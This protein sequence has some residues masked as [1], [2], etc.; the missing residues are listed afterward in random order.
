MKNLLYIMIVLSTISYGQVGRKN[1]HLNDNNTKAST[2]DKE[3]K[4]LYDEFI[5]EGFSQFYIEG[6]GGPTSDGIEILG[7][8]NGNWEIYYIERGQRQKTL[9]SS[10][11]KKE[12]IDFYRN[13]IYRIKHHHL[14]AFTRSKGKIE[15]IKILLGENSI[16]YWQ[17]DIPSYSE[18]GDTVYRIFVF[19]K[20]I[21]RITE[22]DKSLPL[23]EKLK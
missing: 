23:I 20:D 19:N 18:V 6:I 3:L 5:A 9:F 15:Q 8:H 17:N 22:I 13:H 16:E 7:L 10:S 11:D 2:M 21:F 4:D 14:A 1:G 12:A